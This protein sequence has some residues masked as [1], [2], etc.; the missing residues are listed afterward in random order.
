[1]S[2]YNIK[3]NIFKGCIMEGVKDGVIDPKENKYNIEDTYEGEIKDGVIH[4]KGLLTNV[5]KIGK[6]IRTYIYEGD[7]KNGLKHGKGI[8][9]YYGNRYEG[10][11]EKGQESG[12]GIK[13]YKNGDRYEGDFKN[14]N[15]YGKGIYTYLQGYIYNGDYVYNE[16]NGKCIIQ[17]PNG[18]RFEGEFIKNIKSEGT[19]YYPN[20]DRYEGE[21]TKNNCLDLYRHGKGSFFSNG[22]KIEGIWDNDSLVGQQ[23]SNEKT[24]LSPYVTNQQQSPICVIY[25]IVRVIMN[26]IKKF[27]TFDKTKYCNYYNDDLINIYLKNPELFVTLKCTESAKKE[28]ILFCYF[29]FLFKKEVYNLRMIQNVINDFFNKRIVYPFLNEK[30]TKII[31]GI[32]DPLYKKIHSSQFYVKKCFLDDF[33]GLLDKGFY[34]LF[35]V[36]EFNS[37]VTK[38]VDLLPQM[39]LTSMTDSVHAIV[40]RS[41]FYDKKLKEEVF[42]FVNSHGTVNM[43]LNI[44]YS[45]LKNNSSYIDAYYINRVLYESKIPNIKK[46]LC[47]DGKEPH[48]EHPTNKNRCLSICKSGTKRSKDTFRCVKNSSSPKKSKPVVKSPKKILC[49]DGKEPHPEHPTNKNRCL[50]ICKPGTKRSTDTFRCVKNS[51]SPKKS[52]PVV[53]SPKKNLCPDGKEPHPEHPTNKN[54]C[55]S[56]CKPGTK[57]STD[58]FRCVK[59]K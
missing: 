27:I 46:I 58:T 41:H 2:H 44:P 42:S 31:K 49:P 50:S 55:L 37:I 59:N 11:W 12:K 29:Y 26:T 53:S 23:I 52:K 56:I 54:R 7:F 13:T 45:F 43:I 47:P 17:Y 8:G 20:G 16:M 15:L 28:F 3:G 25:S 18:E 5:I 34:I 6:I 36:S 39:K 9:T 14:D 10:N 38:S 35:T 40:L 33:Q 30:M 24:S 4:G 22:K 57:R 32:V 1:M 51:N 21:F 19:M 48:P